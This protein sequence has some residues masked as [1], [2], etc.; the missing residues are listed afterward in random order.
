MCG[1]SLEGSYDTGL[2]GFSV[3]KRHTYICMDPALTLDS[4]LQDPSWKTIYADDT[5]KQ[6]RTVLQE[7]KA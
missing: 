4:P 5:H 6:L 1:V 3:K 2:Q 7:S